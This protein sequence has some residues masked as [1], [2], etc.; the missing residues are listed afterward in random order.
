MP[1][2]LI[3]DSLVAL[4]LVVT[5]GYAYV[6]NTKLSSLRRDKSELEKLAMS[7]ANA[8]IRAEESIGKLKTTTDVLQ[9]RMSKA[10]S[11]RDDLVFL[12]D[13]GDGA[14]DRLERYI[15]DARDIAGVANPAESPSNV[16]PAF[17]IETRDDEMQ[18]ETNM[19]SS[20]LQA[21]DL[22]PPDLTPSDDARRP[23]TATRTPETEATEAEKELLKALRSAG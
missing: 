21:D 3:L 22:S 4:L 11:L 1:Y 12:T 15:R 7:F 2:S 10:E 23:L 17:G 14:A 8:T 5:I 19:V 6:L 13:R 20:L 16:E 18:E 9:S